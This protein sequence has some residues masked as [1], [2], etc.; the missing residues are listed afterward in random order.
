VYVD[1][2]HS[3][4]YLAGQLTPFWLGF[5][6][7]DTNSHPIADAHPGN[8]DAIVFPGQDYNNA[9]I[10]DFNN[11][12]KW[13]DNKL[14]RT[15]SSRM[16]WTDV[17]LSMQ[18]PVVQGLS[19]HFKERWNFIW[20]QKYK[21]KDPG[22]YQ[23]FPDVAAQPPTEDGSGFGSGLL[24]GIG[25]SLNRGL[26]HLWD[27][28]HSHGSMP[29]GTATHMQ[30]VRSAS[31]WSAGTPTEHSIAN[32]Y[33]HAISKARHFV[34]V[35]NQFFITATSREQ[36]P[37][38]NKIGAA[39]VERIVQA[40][41]ADEDFMIIVVMPAV[42]AFAGDLKSDGALGT[43]AIMEFQ[44]NSISRGGHSIMESLRDAGIEDVSKYIAFYNLR[45]YDR[46]NV[47]STMKEVEKQAGVSY[48][49]A[50][51]EHDDAVGA[52]WS[53]HGEET[54]GRR[55]EYERYQQATQNVAD[56]TWDTVA[57]CYMDGGPDLS[58][59]PWQGSEE[60]E[61]K[62]FVSEEL[63]I[64][65]KLLIADDRVVICGS[66]N[67]NDRSQLGNHDSEIAVVIEDPTP[68]E[69]F[70]NGEP[71][72]ASRFAA[73]LRRFIF[74]KH[75]G[76]VPDQRWD[77]PDE[78]WRPVD[79][80]PNH[81]DWDSPGDVLVRDPLHRNFRSLWAQ[82]AK[83][84]TEVFTKVFHNV[85]NDRVRTWK[86]YDEFFSKHF[87]IP[88]SEKEKE[89]E[90]KGEKIQYGHVVREEFPG[91]VKEVKEWLGRVRGSLVEMP[92]D[93]LVD[94]DDIAKEGLELNTLTDELYT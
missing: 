32:A 8:V 49:E 48:E 79:V 56:L 20:S 57:D 68:C 42:P 19:L 4:V 33:I 25:D 21:T 84:N 64:H 47:S 3:P 52:G 22:E 16:G 5:G 13:E 11:V 94:V 40:H 12:D 50:R 70:M 15:K 55:A 80:S 90:A 6:R 82:T 81:Y 45:N 88:G 51:R 14:D 10:M 69:S 74:R 77:R 18:G 67:L 75:L 66:A 1:H 27:H 63:Y 34:Y 71:Y 78:N 35:E 92:L 60:D 59:A 39:M 83:A 86:D 2:W 54:Y 62:A 24:G 9:R 46:I 7:Y 85:P 58:S 89:E 28:D 30:I 23:P 76:L 29:T 26:G 44:Y 61:L 53:P 87:I 37:V 17:A 38:M 93:F 73:S 31:K 41:E 36:A 43:R 91:G 72:K 65:S